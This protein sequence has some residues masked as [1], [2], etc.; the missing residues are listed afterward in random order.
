LQAYVADI[1]PDERSRAKNLALLQGAS[2]TGAF[3]VG[4]PVSVLLSRRT[5]SYRIPVLVAAAS[6]LINMLVVLLIPESKPHLVLAPQKQPQAA[7]SKRKAAVPKKG[8]VQPS[9]KQR[10]RIEPP[11]AA[12][13]TLATPTLRT[14]AV[15]YV[16]AIMAQSSLDDGFLLFAQAQFGWGQQ[17]AAPI[18]ILVGILLAASPQLLIPR[19]GVRGSIAFGLPVVA[20]GMAAICLAPT[21]ALFI[22]GICIVA[23]GFVCLPTML[24]YLT[25]L[26]PDDQKGAALGA[27]EA[28]KTLAKV[29]SA[30]TTP[31][32]F[33]LFM[34]DKAPLGIWLPGAP[35]GWASIV[36]LASYAIQMSVM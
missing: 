3:L 14:L 27:V 11:W 8:P 6:Q 32:A 24:V 16:L 30:S 21:P 22:A 26:V 20:L 15:A 18:L 35:F 12:L 31:A 34:S 19:L 28:L 7:R 17:Q 33:A 2:L 36:A 10:L 5:N 23:V 9:P 13:R 25:S 4:F 29:L 1:S